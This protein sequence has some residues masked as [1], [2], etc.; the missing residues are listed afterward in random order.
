M[1]HLAAAGSHAVNGVARLHTELLKTSVLRDFHDFA[2]G[3]FSNK[4]N[5]ITPRR[6]LALANPRLSALI[7]ESIGEGWT[8]DLEELRRLEPFASDSGFREAWRRVKRENKAALAAEIR[9]RVGV[10]VDADTLFDVQI[11]RFHE[12]KRQHLNILRV[13]ARYREIQRGV[14]EGPPRTIVFAGK[15]APGYLMAKLIIKLINSVADVVNRD[16]A[17]APF[18]KVVFVPDYNV[19]NARC[20]VP[21]AD[22]SE[23]ISTAGKEASGT[24]N[25]KLALNGALTIGTYDGANIE[26]REEVGAENFFLFGMTAEEVA[27]RKNEGYRPREHYERDPALREALDLVAGGTFSPEQPALFG[28]L[29]DSLLERDDYMVLADYA[30]Y[31]DR[32]RD[33]DRTYRDPDRWTRMSILNT[34]RMGKFSS[35]RA[36]REYCRDIWRVEP[37]DVTYEPGG[38]L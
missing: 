24:G 2:P 22:L 28:P 12:Y 18:L 4:T 25:M 27:S 20:L 36:I 16:P 3:S 14:A 35:D 30:A 9:R 29:V 37:V 6:F 26:I 23:Q 33:V 10:E 17:I 8:H 34:S 21:A 15:A 7:T 5:G 32:Q 11:K 1:A 31:A 19:K 13:V 38:E